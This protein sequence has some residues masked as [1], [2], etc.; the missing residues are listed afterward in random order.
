MDFNI[1]TAIIAFIGAEFATILFE[2]IFIY[3]IP[4]FFGF[5]SVKF[6]VNHERILRILDTITTIAVAVFFYMYI[7]DPT[8]LS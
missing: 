3:I 8:I 5:D 6:V 1:F 7:S 4:D 2:V